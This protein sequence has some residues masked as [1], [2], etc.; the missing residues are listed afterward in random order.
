MTVETSATESSVKSATQ[1]CPCSEEILGQC[2]RKTKAEEK[3][4]D[5]LEGRDRPGKST[6]KV[7]QTLSGISSRILSN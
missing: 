6:S 1:Q 7:P 3:E 2:P 4:G 5:L